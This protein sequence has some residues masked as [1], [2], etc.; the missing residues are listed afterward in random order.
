[1]T[2]LVGIGRNVTFMGVTTTSGCECRE[3]EVI[4]FKGALKQF[5]TLCSKS[6]LSNRKSKKIGVESTKKLV[7]FINVLDGFANNIKLVT[8]CFE[9]MSILSNKFGA[10]FHQQ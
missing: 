5:K 10:A 1:M 6:D 3:S 9:G 2:S 7:Q 8:N 4:S